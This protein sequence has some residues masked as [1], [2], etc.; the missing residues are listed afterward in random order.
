MPV[1]LAP[2][3]AA[4]KQGFSSRLKGALG[5]GVVVLVSEDQGRDGTIRASLSPC[6]GK[7]RAVIFHGRSPGGTRVTAAAQSM[8]A[9][10]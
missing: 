8:P 2:T 4:K 7:V 3:V 9:F 6:A 10:M 1:A 5:C